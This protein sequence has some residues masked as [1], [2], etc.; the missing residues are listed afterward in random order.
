[1]M[2][3]AKHQ[4]AVAKK[5][6]RMTPVAAEVMGGMTFREAYKHVFRTDLDQR[7]AGLIKTYPYCEDAGFCWELQMYGWHNPRELQRALPVV[8]AQEGK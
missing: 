4:M 8:T 1:M 2:T 6:L 5:T 7:I 3:A